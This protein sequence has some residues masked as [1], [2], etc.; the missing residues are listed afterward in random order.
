[1]AQNMFFRDFWVF[2]V[3]LRNTTA[4]K[5]P[6]VVEI[7]S[8]TAFN[9]LKMGK[10]QCFSNGPLGQKTHFLAFFDMFM[11]LFTIYPLYV[12]WFS[13]VICCELTKNH[14]FVKYMSVAV[15]ISYFQNGK[16]R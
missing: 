1:M 4:R 15:C 2:Q 6:I 9:G 7:W 16:I 13:S 11:A 14:I 5:S 8:Y 12:A 3:L 10:N